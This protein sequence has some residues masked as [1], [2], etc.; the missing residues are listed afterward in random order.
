MAWQ[1]YQHAHRLSERIPALQ[2]RSWA[3]ATR[4]FF[5]LERILLLASLAALAAFSYRVAH[6]PFA[7]AILVEGEPVAAVARRGTAEAILDSL[8]RRQCGSLAE[9]ARFNREV[10][11]ER[12]EADAQP[13]L[14]RWQALTKIGR[15]VQVEVPAHRL[16]V[17][18]KHVATMTSLEDLRGALGEV[19]ERWVPRRGRL[20][21]AP[22]IRGKVVIES[23]VLGP[24][25]AREEVLTR[26]Q[27]IDRLLSP[28]VAPTVYVVKSGDTAARIAARFGVSLEDLER[29]NPEFD[30]NRLQVGD[31]LIVASEVPVLSVAAVVEE[32]REAPV[33]Y[34]TQEIKSAS[35]KPGERKVIRPGKHGV[36]R[37][38]ERVT[39]LNGEPIRRVS[40]WEEIE[41]EPVPE[42]VLV[43]ARR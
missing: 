8:K 17:N 20:L 5:T 28:A 24:Q 23:V 11:I 40:S 19:I 1:F 32:V 26:G 39:Y 41:K 22:K 14:G 3:H 27:T 36:Q 4:R 25:Q 21:G 34:W 35:L 16:F 42:Q 33:D 10:A 13:V 12:V 9:E 43:G 18:G 15:A 38:R 6:P 7:W 37:V 30:L 2:V 31:R 29:A